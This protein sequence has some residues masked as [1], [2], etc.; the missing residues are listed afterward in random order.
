M[1]DAAATAPPDSDAARRELAFEEFG[2]IFLRRVLH[3]DRVLESVDR[4]LGP[5]FHLG[6]M[7]AGPGR[8]MAT[9]TADGRFLPTYGEL[10]PGDDE[11][12]YRVMLPV[13]V[14]FDL[15]VKVDT[16]RFH[17]DVLVPLLVRLRLEEPLTIVWDITPPAE[18]GVR[19]EIRGENRRSSLLQRL[20]G[21]DGELRRFLVRFVERELAK[22]YVERARH[23]DVVA[24]IDGA[25]EQIACQFLPNSPED[26]A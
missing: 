8:K 23:I 21:F 22:P 20:A 15:D 4:I 5:D 13:D 3:T 17:A 9:L 16:Q 2:A 11:V 19:I 14:T 10:L 1:S 7:G 12:V 6:P 25:W 24:V 26:R 18:D